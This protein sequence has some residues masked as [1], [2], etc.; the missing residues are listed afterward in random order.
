MQE[1]YAAGDLPFFWL[2][3]SP[4]GISMAKMI[5]IITIW[6]LL[7]IPDQLT[8]MLAVRYLKG[9]SPI[10]LI[11]G[12][13]E[14]SYVENA[15]AAFGI[16]QNARWFFLILTVAILA[17]LAYIMHKLVQKPDFMAL[18]TTLCFI[19]AGAV[20]NMIDRFTHGYVVDFIYFKLIDF[21]VFNVAD[22]YVTCSAFA[23]AILIFAVYKDEDLEGIFR[24]ERGDRG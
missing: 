17:G 20:G 15:G 2:K 14:L 4:K 5:K 22:I 3:Q 9:A 8:K 11:K 1:P 12:I 16:L 13:L 6:V 24:K 19:A 18:K 10:V 23:L 7:V 21:P